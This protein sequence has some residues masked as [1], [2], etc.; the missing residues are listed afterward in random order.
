MR[1][2]EERGIALADYFQMLW[3][4]RWLIVAVLGLTTV[5]AFLTRPEQPQ[6]LYR[7]QVTLRVQI[8]SVTGSGTSSNPTGVPPQELEQARN[9]EVA[10][11]TARALGQDDDGVRLL[12]GLEVSSVENTDLLQIALLGRG[13]TTVQQLQEYAKNYVEYRNKLDEDRLSRALQQ[14]DARIQAVQGRLQVLSAAVARA[15]AGGRDTP[16][17]LQTQI[18]ATTTIYQRFLELREQIQLDSVLT[19]NTVQLI[20][21]AITQ[22]L[23]AIP[24]RTLRLVAGPIVGFM[25]G[26][27]LAIALGVLRPKISSRERSEE[28]LGYPVLATIPLVKK[29]GVSRD[30]L[31]IQRSSPWGVE[32]VR[33]LQTELQLVEKR[34]GR[35]KVVVIASPEPGDGRTTV[36]VNLAGSF[37]A[38][39][40]SVALLRADRVAEIEEE[41]R[42]RALDTGPLET[43][44]VRMHRDGFAEVVP[45]VM[46]ARNQPGLVGD[47]LTGVVED[48]AGDFEVVVIDTRPLST[49]ADSL[50]L[51]GQADAVVVVLRQHETAEARAIESID[52]LDR[53]GVSIVGL[54]L[55]AARAPLIE[56]YRARSA[57]ASRQQMEDLRESVARQTRARSDATASPRTVTL[58]PAPSGVTPNGEAREREMRG[59]Q[60]TGTAPPDA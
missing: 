19:G 47:A 28:R 56:R 57:A 42:A 29:A 11:T 30:P 20:G 4:R 32:G 15:T 18:R 55:N 46:R 23:G 54:V 51:A 13:A 49:S 34:G 48:L 14:V 43:I 5:A 39:G 37:A 41:P 26:A 58:P 10:A 12:E 24:T 38:A 40:R 60:P 33:M 52:I 7:S 8:L 31:L 59:P 35:V 1:N 36:A 9:A 25:L 44:L 27:A 6:P 17:D 50:L 53:H 21:S 22:R 45:K 16:L 3:E 2:R